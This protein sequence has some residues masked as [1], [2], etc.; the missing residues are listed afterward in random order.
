[1]QI[2]ACQLDI[3]WED[4]PRNFERVR[5]LLSGVA[6]DEGALV[7]LP[8][9]FS[10]G[11]SMNVRAIAEPS[12]GPTVRFVSKLA[13]DRRCWVVAGAVSM[14][15]NDR[16]RNEALV[17]GPDGTL[18]GRYVKIHPFT[19]GGETGHY[20]AGRDILVLDVGGVR[21]APFICYDLR[22]PEVFRRAVRKGHPLAAQGAQLLVVIANWP[23]ARDEHW[24]ALLR[25]RAIEN[26]AFVVGVNRV[27]HDPKLSYV[28]HSAIIDP[29]GKALASAGQSA[30]VISARLDFSDLLEYR[31][32]FPAIYDMHDEFFPDVIE[33]GDQ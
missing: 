7:V 14:A 3:A 1:M 8:E 6:I 16:G 11:F 22:F 20:S 27:G 18:R 28:G 19:Y 32:S 4:K 21:A 24:T 2:I 31:R 26:Q 17:V 30:E 12:D 25:A 33:E 10:T 9:M 29:R 5:E 13:S 23:E 15:D